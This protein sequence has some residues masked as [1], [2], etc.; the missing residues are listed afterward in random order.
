MA[1]LCGTHPTTPT[2]P[3]VLPSLKDLELLTS[4]QAQRRRLY[5]LAEHLDHPR[6]GEGVADAILEARDA[7]DHAVKLQVE[8]CR[9]G[10]QL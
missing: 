2:P 10:G 4:L 5:F 6:V 8:L 7:I 3:A 9:I 1:I